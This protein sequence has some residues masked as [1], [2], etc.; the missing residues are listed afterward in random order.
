MNKFQMYASLAVA[1][2][3]LSACDSK[4]STPATSETSSAP[5]QIATPAAGTIPDSVPGSSPGEGGTAI[6]GVA[7][8]PQDDQG[9]T[10]SDAPASTGGD[11][12]GTP[13]TK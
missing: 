9:A 4:K 13:A 6:G 12:N 7:S 1:L 8:T 3:A 2:L 11:G 10:K 5:A